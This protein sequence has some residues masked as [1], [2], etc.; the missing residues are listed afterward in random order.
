MNVTT[1]ST[2]KSVPTILLRFCSFIKFA[3]F[4]EEKDPIIPPIIAKIKRL[5]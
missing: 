3:S 2:N 4:A 5:H 1:P